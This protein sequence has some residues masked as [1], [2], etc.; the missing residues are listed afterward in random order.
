MSCSGLGS[1]NPICAI[2]SSIG[3]LGS[4]V[5]NSVFSS[6]AT[7]FGNTADSAI[8]WLWSQ[9]SSSTSVTLGG[10]AYGLDLGL[11]TS[12]AAVLCVGLFIVQLVTSALK[13]DGGG[14]GR[15]LRGLAIATVGCAITLATLELLLSAVDQL[16]AGVVQLA[17]GDSI[18]TLGAKIIGPAMFTGLV[19]GPGAI[20]ILSLIAI[21]AVAMVWFA[22]VV[23]K[24]LIIITAIFAPL[25]FAGGVADVSRGWVRKWLEAM[26]ALVF[27]K[28]I[29]ILIFVIGLGVLGGMG[30]PANAGGLSA[31]T[32]D[33]TGLLILLVAGLSPWMALK[34]V[35]F[36]GDHMA[37]MAGSASHATSGASTVIG[38]PQKMA[39]M[40]WAA[41][42]LGGTQQKA[43]APMGRGA[44]AA[45]G[46]P[47]G[48]TTAA[49]GASVGGST[50][51]G[52][53][54]AAGAGA[55]TAGV[56][57]AGVALAASAA[58][59]VTKSA[60]GTVRN[61]VQDGSAAGGHG[62]NAV[63]SVGARSPV[64][65]SP[66]SS[67]GATATRESPA[68]TPASPAS[69]LA[70]STPRRPASASDL[71]LPSTAHHPVDEP[72]AHSTSFPSSVPP[73]RFNRSEFP[74]P[75]ESS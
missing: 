10:A 3:S 71:P 12:I 62:A 28:L 31:I 60:G 69:H 56:A 14:I 46:A 19:A 25:A 1:A 51:V 50:G 5:T 6:V 39:S 7:A 18:A 11:V 35:H 68:S 34:L 75:K 72:T 36:T 22:L 17:T 52:S 13:Q 58:R 61:G 8:N 43:G 73:L 9:M 27:S 40:K 74:T 23:R 30:S 41:Q 38:A 44:P 2:V 29:L 26:L 45:S 20:L 49:S 54:A 21:C 15:A 47:S 16:C 4:S 53:A 48:A 42:S 33:I 67:D 63:A 55:T 65:T 59:H 24:M 32:N 66:A 64:T 37:T 70:A 57:K